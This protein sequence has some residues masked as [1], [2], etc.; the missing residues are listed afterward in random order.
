MTRRLLLLIALV[1]LSVYLLKFHSGAE[2]R[3]ASPNYSPSK[4][5]D[6][7]PRKAQVLAVSATTGVPEKQTTRAL[8]NKYAQLAPTAAD[9]A[10]VDDVV[11]SIVRGTADKVRLSSA[12]TEA[13]KSNVAEICAVRAALECERA[14]VTKNEN[15]TILVKIPAD[16]GAAVELAKVAREQ[17]AAA[18]GVDRAREIYAAL[19][20]SLG[21]FAH[22]YGLADQTIVF[23]PSAS[24]DGTYDSY[25]HQS[26]PEPPPEDVPNMVQPKTLDTWLYSY[27]KPFDPSGI[28]YDFAALRVVLKV[29]APFT[30]E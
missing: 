18:V 20:P 17:F 10:F 26:K 4:N 8:W 7:S 24:N 19:G 15:G 11:S 27:G 25:Y 22:L 5:S 6:T 28:Q 13:L 29:Q 9:K 3:V 21:S 23:T 16:P 12:E 14:Q 30:R 2:T 1:V